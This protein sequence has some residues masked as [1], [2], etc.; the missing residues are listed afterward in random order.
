M[1]D[2]LKHT[3]VPI[4]TASHHHHVECYAVFKVEQLFAASSFHTTTEQ[5][6]DGRFFAGLSTL[7]I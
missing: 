5:K 7:E 4:L 2:N 1:V 6:A 3:Y